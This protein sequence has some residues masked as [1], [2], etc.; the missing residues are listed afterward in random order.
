MGALL[1]PVLA[2]I[3]FNLPRKKPMEDGYLLDVLRRTGE[4]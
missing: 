4:H 3:L 1:D 2:I